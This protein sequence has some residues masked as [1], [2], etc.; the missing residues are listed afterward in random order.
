MSRL[1]V[2]IIE[3]KLHMQHTLCCLLPLVGMRLH[4]IVCIYTWSHMAW[5][6]ATLILNLLLSLNNLLYWHLK[7]MT[8][9]LIMLMDDFSY[10]GKSSIF[11]DI[12]AFFLHSLAKCFSWYCRHACLLNLSYLWVNIFFLTFSKV[13]FVKCSSSQH[14]F[15]TFMHMLFMCHCSLNNL[16]FSFLP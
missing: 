13:I 8:Y 1:I 15:G 14:L 3:W 5:C 2:T 16:S 10:Y 7:L 4:W 11:W 9:M 6:A 12:L